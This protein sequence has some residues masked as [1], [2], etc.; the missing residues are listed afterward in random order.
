MESQTLVSYIS[1]HLKQGHSEAALRQR[2]LE[3]GW[4]Q[5]AVDEAFVHLKQPMTMELSPAAKRTKRSRIKPRWTRARLIKLGAVGALTLTLIVGV[6]FLQAYR[7]NHKPV[8]ARVTMSARQKQAID[9]NNVGGAVGQYAQ[10]NGTTPTAVSVGPDGN[11]VLCSSVCDPTTYEVVRLLMYQ[12]GNVKLHAYASG[13]AV[14]DSQTLY[15]VADAS[16]TGPAKAIAAGTSTRAMAILYSP[17]GDTSTSQH[18]V[19]L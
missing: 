17:T 7:A 12:P 6:H 13:I 15:L 5:T 4:S 8:V 3:K 9:I 18:C 19:T 14:P 11:L 1:E 2:L 10:L 16:C